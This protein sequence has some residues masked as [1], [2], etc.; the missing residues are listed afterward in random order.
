M[1]EKT[2]KKMKMENGMMKTKNN[3]TKNLEKMR[4]LT[5]FPLQ[6]RHF[7]QK[8]EKGMKKKKLEL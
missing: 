5:S 4:T 6:K 7:L 8:L 3:A 2:K 1:L